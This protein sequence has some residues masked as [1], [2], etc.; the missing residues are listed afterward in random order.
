MQDVISAQQDRG[1]RGGRGGSQ[2][3]GRGQ[4]AGG[5]GAGDRGIGRGPGA[6][7]AGRG[8]S[9]PR[10][11]AAAPQQS[12]QSTARVPVTEQ[13]AVTASAA[14]LAVSAAPSAPISSG[15][16]SGWGSGGTTL[17]EKLKQA[18]IQKL[19]PPVVIHQEVVEESEVTSRLHLFHDEPLPCSYFHHH[20]FSTGPSR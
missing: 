7:S 3:G 2:S 16:S 8:A 15:G 18:E 5:R 17:A 14:P 13:S 9:V 12:H 6:P 4:G 10:S 1:G 11:A 20:L 19:S